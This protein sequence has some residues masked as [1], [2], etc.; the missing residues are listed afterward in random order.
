[1]ELKRLKS[2]LYFVLGNYEW[3]LNLKMFFIKMF[4]VTGS[5][6]GMQEF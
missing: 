2:L 5:Y 6:E 1:M 3:K 4:I